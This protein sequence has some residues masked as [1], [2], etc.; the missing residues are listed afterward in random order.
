MT[1]VMREVNVE[2]IR[3]NE[4]FSDKKIIQPNKITSELSI[5]RQFDACKLQTIPV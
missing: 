1:T 5:E 4:A 2:V 3:T